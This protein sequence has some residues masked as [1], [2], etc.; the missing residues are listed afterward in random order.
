MVNLVS[1][2]EIRQVKKLDN[3]ILGSERL[4]ETTAL[5]L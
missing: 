3:V 2:H 4:I 1:N 5:T